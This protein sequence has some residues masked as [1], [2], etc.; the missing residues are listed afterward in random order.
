MERKKD[1]W[2]IQTSIIKS[3]SKINFNP[4][5]QREYEA[6]DVPAWQSKLIKSILLDRDLPK[7]YVRV[8]NILNIHK[9]TSKK[10][11]AQPYEC[12]DGQQRLRTILDF[13]NDEV[14]LPARC[15]VWYEGTIH[16]LGGMTYSEVEAYD[17]GEIINDLFHNYDLDVTYLCGSD[18]EMSDI[19]YDLN[20]L[21]SMNPQQK[22]NC[23][24]SDVAV[25]VR[26][27][28][29]NPENKEDVKHSL[30]DICDDIKR[31]GAYLGF[32]SKKMAFDNLLAEMC[33]YE[34]FG[35]TKGI[36]NKELN[37]SLYREPMFKKSFPFREAVNE[38]LNHT[39]KT[40]ENQ[41]YTSAANKNVVTNLY[42][43]VNYINNTYSKVKFD[44]GKFADW[45][46]ETHADLKTLTPKMKKDKL[47]E[48]PYSADTR[49]GKDKDAVIRRINYFIDEL[50]K[51]ELID[52]GIVVRDNKRVINDV[53]T[54]SL[55]I[56]SKKKCQACDKSL[57]LGEVVKGH[58]T[59]WSKGGKSIKDNTVILCQSC[60]SKQGDMDFDEFKKLEEMV[61]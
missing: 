56:K 30:F 57:K 51:I 14:K 29:R 48:T 25:F 17:D 6:K 10:S 27:T 50:N 12:V 58:K 33:C 41:D 44:Y 60:N 21:N 26:D 7:L 55:Y 38:N 4:A 37:N 54:L 19:F 24:I 52:A 5:Y 31:D 8:E 45:F 23:I 40:L 18:E 61:A 9:P 59:A 11:W 35:I 53:D 13:S 39:Y 49:V 32:K 47:Y 1:H 46:F 2:S 42:M 28:A 22:R 36:G 20:D 15:D 43:V 16:E 3:K 34:A